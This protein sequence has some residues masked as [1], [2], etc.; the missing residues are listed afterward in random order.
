MIKKRITAKPISEKWFYGL[1]FAIPLLAVFI[2]FALAHSFP[3]GNSSLLTTDLGQ[4][5]IDFYQYYRRVLLGHPDQFFY[6]F[7][8]SLGGPMLGTWAYYLLS[9][10]NLILLLTPGK[11]LTVGVWLMTAIKLGLTGWTMFYFLDHRPQHAYLHHEWQLALSLAYALCGYTTAYQLNIMWLD[12]VILLPLIMLGLEYL[13]NRG[14]YWTYLWT[15]SLAILT[16]YY[17]GYMLCLFSVLYFSYLMISNWSANKRGT[18]IARFSLSSLLAGSLN[19]W[20]LLPNL[21]ELRASKATYNAS[22]MIWRFQYN[23]L[24]LIPKLMLGSYSFDQMSSGQANIFTGTI[25]LFLALLFFLLR[26]I[27]GRQKLAAGGI[28]LFLLLSFCLEPL[29]LLWH[30]G[31]FPVWYPSRFS[32]IFSAWLIILASSALA[33]RQNLRLWQVGVLGGFMVAWLGYLF[34]NQNQI[35]YLKPINLAFTCFFAIVSFFLIMFY[36]SAPPRNLLRFALAIVLISELLIN[37]QASLQQI[38]YTR[39]SE[40]WSY[41]GLLNNAL[42]EVNPKRLQT[43]RLEKTFNRTNDDPFQ[44]GY[45]GGQTFNSML[46]PIIGKFYD[47]IGQAAGDNFV[48]YK[49]GTQITDSLLGYQ[50]WLTTNP[51]I[52]QELPELPDLS[53]GLTTT[54]FRPD[55]ASYELVKNTGAVSIYQNTNALNYVFAANQ[56]ITKTSLLDNQPVTN[57]E[58]ILAGLTGTN[59]YQPLYSLVNFD[60][61]KLTNLTRDTP[62][63]AAVY[64]RKMNE[65]PGSVTFTF[66]P[67]TNNSY[68]LSLGSVV[69]SDQISLTVN[70]ENV[71]INENFRAAILLNVA[72]REIGKKINITISLKK[73]QVYLQNINLYQ[74]DQ[75]TVNQRF[76]QLKS[77]NAKL[78]TV[79]GDQLAGTI[80]LNKNQLLMTTI[81]ANT[82]WQLYVDGQKQPTQKVLKTFLGVKL[83]TGKH[84]FEFKFQPVGWLTGWIIT[85]VSALIIAALWLK[86]Q[87]TSQ[88][89]LTFKWR[90][91][92]KK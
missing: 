55:V 12:G 57:Q 46:D 67:T 15:L 23:P 17:I 50:T 34:F 73:N 90:Q 69:N 81:P 53:A 44:F 49:Y 61:V 74:L 14:K 22:K 47:Q 92:L 28:T 60:Q 62:T 63:P 11:W 51:A 38:S 54:S 76:K 39:Q 37:Y 3:F 83:S 45:A 79:K 10:L 26:A 27:P 64:T 9:P 58:R 4:E 91:R 52:N 56:A 68:Y 6:S 8:S 86:E 40:Y 89:G 65:L 19:V 48:N 25:V 72:R 36:F 77:G 29:D 21:L 24:K 41:T 75:T 5:Y 30:G 1:S 84:Q 13:V 33:H 35:D 31:Q 71:P 85:L 70:D 16:N 43:Q 32:F 82:G 66:T 78:T 42:K 18:I 88:Q 7:S 20:L 87:A 59:S 2:Y 80:K